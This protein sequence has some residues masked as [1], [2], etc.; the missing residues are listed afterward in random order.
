MAGRQ[1]GNHT[2]THTPHLQDHTN[3]WLPV[4]ETHT[5]HRLQDRT[6]GCRG[7]THTHTHPAYKTAQMA[8]CRSGKHTHTHIHSAYKIT[9]MAD[10]WLEKHTHTY[11]L[12][13]LVMVGPDKPAIPEQRCSVHVHTPHLRTRLHRWLIASQGYTHIHTPIHMDCKFIPVMRWGISRHVLLHV[14]MYYLVE[15]EF[16]FQSL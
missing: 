5:T 14:M 7:N 6:N 4:G 2:H 13:N 16:H 3:G 15:L 8:D 10:H 1:S 12:K 9:Q 11:T